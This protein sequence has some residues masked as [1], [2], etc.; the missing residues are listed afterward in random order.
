MSIPA[1]LG[2]LL[3]ELKDFGELNVSGA[4]IFNY[5]V[6]MLIAAVVGYIC[7]KTM[8]VVVR[9]KKFTIFAIYCLII[10]IVSVAGYFYMA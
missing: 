8:L 4:E 3:L 9:K 1:I 10:G 6:G 7:I 5:I 2:S